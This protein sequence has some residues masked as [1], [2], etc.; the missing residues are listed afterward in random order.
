MM[1]E[2]GKLTLYYRQ[3]TD[4]ACQKWSGFEIDHE[5]HFDSYAKVGVYLCQYDG[6]QIHYGKFVIG[7]HWGKYLLEFSLKKG[8]EFHKNYMDIDTTY[9]LGENE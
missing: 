4:V 9:N 2:L 6:V 5:P 1:K 3:Q 7:A 8:F